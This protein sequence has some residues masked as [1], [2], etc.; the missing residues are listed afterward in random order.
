MS[1]GTKLT[2]WLLI[3]LLLV[4]IFFATVTLRRER[5]V[6]QQEVWEEAER[7]A[8]SLA[9]SIGE[10]L[11]RRNLADIHRIAEESALEQSRF[12]LAVYDPQGRPILTWGLAAAAASPQVRIGRPCG[13]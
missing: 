1:L 13:S 7:I 9:I 5:D 2:L 3:P 11:R 10:A 6:H 12:G 4:L 8:N